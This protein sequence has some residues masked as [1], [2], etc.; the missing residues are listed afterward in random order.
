[1]LRAVPFDLDVSQV[2]IP[3]D[4]DPSAPLQELEGLKHV[5]RVRLAIAADRIV[6]L[7]RDVVER[8]VRRL[9]E[10][11][12]RF[13]EEDVPKNNAADRRVGVQLLVL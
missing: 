8:P 6:A 5:L 13:G 7:D 2:A 3:V 10:F 4:V 11:A 12:A 1:M 9:G